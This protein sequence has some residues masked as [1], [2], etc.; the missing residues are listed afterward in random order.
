MLKE[1]SIVTQTKD[2]E[3]KLLGQMA[4]VNTLRS[5]SSESDKKVIE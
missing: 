2:T 5:L 3:A 4:S 1:C